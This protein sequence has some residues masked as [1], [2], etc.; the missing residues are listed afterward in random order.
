M[1]AVTLS[2]REATNNDLEDIIQLYSQPDMD[3]GKVLSAQQA[4][5]VFSR[6][7]SYPNY[8]IYVAEAEGQIVG[9]YALAIMDNLTHMGSPSGLIED[10]VVKTNH[11][12]SGIGRQ[13]MQYAITCC[14]KQGCYKVALSSN[15]KREGAHL[16]YENLGF[17]KHGYSFLMELEE[18]E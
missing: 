15:L 14:R 12:G 7:N 2:I 10:V 16:F 4:Q 9:T 11:Q 6:I 18:G 3:D 13:M 8:K 5:A 1:R 17:K